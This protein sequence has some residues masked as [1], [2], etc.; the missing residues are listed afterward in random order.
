MCG[1][2]DDEHVGSPHRAGEDTCG[3]VESLASIRM[4]PIILEY[5]LPSSVVVAVPGADL[6]LVLVFSSSIQMSLRKTERIM[7]NVAPSG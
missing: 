2:M 3:G 4:D 5:L 7:P 6:L 1:E